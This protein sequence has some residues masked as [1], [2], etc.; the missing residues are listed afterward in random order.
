[1]AEPDGLPQLVRIEVVN[2]NLQSAPKAWFQVA[3][4]N[5]ADMQ[6]H[7]WHV[8]P[9]ARRKMKVRKAK[10]RHRRKMR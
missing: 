8:G 2:G 7:R 9:S 5:R 10:Q 6:H 4:E 3:A 1:M